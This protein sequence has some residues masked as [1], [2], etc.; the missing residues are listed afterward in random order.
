M[1][2][3]PKGPAAWTRR[4]LLGIRDLSRGELDAVLALARKLKKS[5]PATPL[6]K[7]RRLL[8]FFVEASTRT[9]T[10]FGIA[11]RSTIRG[12]R[13]AAI[14]SDVAFEPGTS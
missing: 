7:G 1:A 13:N 14:S 11:A 12:A 10:S 2:R 5:P 6:L 3:I 9:K 4:H 8:T